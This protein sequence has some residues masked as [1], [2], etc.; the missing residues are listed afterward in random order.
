MT[1]PYMWKNNMWVSGT[2]WIGCRH[3]GQGDL[4]TWCAR[5]FFLNVWTGLLNSI[6]MQLKRCDLSSS[7]ALNTAIYC[8]VYEG[9][10]MRQQDSDYQSGAILPHGR[11][12][13]GWWEEPEQRSHLWMEM[14]TFTATQSHS[15]FQ[16]P[17]HFSFWCSPQSTVWMIANQHNRAAS[18]WS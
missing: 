8:N 5:T 3:R 4:H 1:T 18:T 15:E 6:L 12:Q 17:I 16:G 14:L 9:N 11:E 7:I 13:D 10:I 2:A